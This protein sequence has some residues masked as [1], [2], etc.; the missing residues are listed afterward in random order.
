MNIAHYIIS[1]T[2]YALAMSGLIALALIVYKKVTNISCTN[3]KTKTL[4]IE[5][6]MSINPRKTL[7]IVK[8]GDE[9]FL[10]ASD[11]DKTTLISKLGQNE[12]LTTQ[13]QETQTTQ[14]PKSSTVINLQQIKDSIDKENMEVL[15][16]K[17]LKKETKT[18]KT[19][20]N[21]KTSK[22]AKQPVE[23]KKKTVHLEVISDKNPKGAELRKNRSYMQTRRRNVTIEVGEIKNHGF[24][25]IKELVHKVNEI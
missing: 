11:I 15:F 20:K 1:F 10:I 7:M 14:L 21:E 19:E 4:S 18:V 25:T 5:E 23:E 16:P 2:V 8:A 24:S 9:R 3:K 22:P 6:T 12:T 17:K 13:T